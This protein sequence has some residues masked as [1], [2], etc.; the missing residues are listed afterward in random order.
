MEPLELVERLAG[1]QIG[2][3]YN[4][5]AESTLL[6]QRLQQSFVATPA[7]DRAVVDRLSHLDRACRMHAP[8]GLVEIDTG[9]VPFEGAMREHGIV[10]STADNA[11]SSGRWQCVG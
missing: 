8:L 3:T 4:Q 5:Y 6:Q 7:A 1:T 9:I 10:D 11:Q 2:E